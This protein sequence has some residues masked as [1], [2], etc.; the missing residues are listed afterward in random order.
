MRWW[1]R[2]PLVLLRRRIPPARRWVIRDKVLRA[3][4]NYA[5]PQPRY[6]SK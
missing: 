3:D 1:Q 4:R 6:E 2:F 5:A